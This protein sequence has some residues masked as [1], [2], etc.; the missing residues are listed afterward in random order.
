MQLS[1]DPL[2]PATFGFNNSLST[3]VFPNPWG[4]PP[5]INVAGQV[6]TTL[7]FTTANAVQFQFAGNW[8]AN[9]G[10]PAT[11][12]RSVTLY[13]GQAELWSFDTANLGDS[14]F[15]QRNLAAGAYRLVFA[16]SLMPGSSTVTG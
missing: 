10:N 2:T 9:F 3:Q 7:S 13:Q 4:T 1:P 12:R 6:Q 16:S 14:L 5:S 11:F 8:V 15:E